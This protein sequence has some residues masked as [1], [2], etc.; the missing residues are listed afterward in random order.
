M[1]DYMKAFNKLV[2]QFTKNE[3][4]DAWGILR[5]E[6][7]I[8]NYSPVPVEPGTGLLIID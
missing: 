4:P 6:E 3:K 1:P 7:V 8:K 5:T 2:N